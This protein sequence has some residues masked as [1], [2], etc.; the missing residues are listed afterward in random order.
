MTGPWEKYQSVET[1]GPWSKYQTLAAKSAPDSGIP[2]WGQEHPTLYKV[3]A[4][5]RDVLGPVAE[6]GGTI[7]GGI[8]GSPLGPMGTIGGAALGYA[9]PK[10]V[11]DVADTALG[12]K[13]PMTAAQS[14][15]QP[16]Q[17]LQ[18]GAIYELGGRA[19]GVPLKAAGNVIR[20]LPYQ[21][22][23]NMLR[24]SLGIDVPGGVNMLRSAKLGTS[25]SEA[26]S[27]GADMSTGTAP[28]NAPATQALLGVA[29][30]RTP[31]S[32]QQATGTQAAQQSADLD[33]LAQIAGGR[34][35]TETAL[36]RQAAGR[37]LRDQ[38]NPMREQ[39][40]SLANIAGE[41]APRLEAQAQ[42][43]E[44]AAASKVADVRK[45]ERVKEKAEEWSA[46]WAP[47]HMQGGRPYLYEDL[48][49]QLRQYTYPGELAQYAEQM[50]QQAA[51]G[52]LD[53]GDAARFSR[54]ALDSLKA[55]G[56]E[57]LKADSIVSKLGGLAQNP[58]Y[59]GN[60]P[61]ERGIRIIS[62]NLEKWTNADGVIDANALYAIRKNSLAE[63][64]RQLGA[65][66]STVPKKA[67]AEVMA[68]LR[69]IVDDAIEQAGGAGW[70]DYLKTFSEGQQELSRRELA[71]EAM[72]L[73][74]KNPKSYVELMN[75]DKP[76]LVEKLMGPGVTDIRQALGADYPAMR[77][78]AQRTANRTAAE[79][80]AS[81]G[82]E[83]LRGLLADHMTMLGVRLPHFISAKVAMANKT[84]DIL[85]RRMDRKTMD[86]LTKAAPEAK[87]I[88]D[89]VER[90]PKKYRSEI[91][92]VL[93]DPTLWQNANVTGGATAGTTNA[94]STQP[95]QNSLT[96]P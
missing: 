57:P 13:K 92:A 19:V 87:S 40:L 58:S 59:A 47:S 39:A 82:Q 60:V 21:R 70:R 89:L 66:A 24:D 30:R 50:S 76:E 18:E 28:F 80:Q 73:F 46:T 94:L 53:F 72:D 27:A 48:P 5:T 43:M 12:R 91:N 23:S 1:Q 63:L 10:Q 17:N 44:Q 71:S 54:Y 32:I 78:I 3:A 6:A 67:A 55:H 93:N 45:L 33:T 16:L 90:V 81:A 68:K 29:E 75:G 4:G 14:A 9:I 65:G 37:A 61:L 2:E 34:T 7:V 26:L 62:R 79:A 31:A 35:Q 41:Q 84:L 64:E 52:S 88:A 49:S 8:V 96:G 38:T 85:A 11:L 83:A 56:L 15:I 25:A 20:N 77:Q 95:S 69:P 42:R 22:A 51:K 74:R 86:I 36:Q